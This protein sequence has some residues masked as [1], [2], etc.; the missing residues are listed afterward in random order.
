[1]PP[2]LSS[3]RHA[4]PTG[5]M[6]RG[7]RP[8]RANR[9]RQRDPALHSN[10]GTR[11]PADPRARSASERNRQPRGHVEISHSKPRRAS[12]RENSRCRAEIKHAPTPHAK[13]A[14]RVGDVTI[15]QVMLAIV[16]EIAPSNARV[17]CVDFVLFFRRGAHPIL[18]QP[19]AGLCH[20]LH[21]HFARLATEFAR[22]ATSAL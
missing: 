15:Q 8:H 20:H 10:R 7:A 17:P 11:A 12:A 5:R 3:A 4:S 16:V 9:S 18:S 14:E 1:M 22:L 21:G 13:Q 2:G 19:S 6:S